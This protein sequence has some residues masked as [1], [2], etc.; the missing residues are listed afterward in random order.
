MACEGRRWP[1]VVHGS[2][3]ELLSKT[4]RP[5]VREAGCALCD[6]D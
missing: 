1:L 4:L 3:V 6:M 5:N 2:S